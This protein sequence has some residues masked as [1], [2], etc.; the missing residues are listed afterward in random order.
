MAKQN[1]WLLYTLAVRNTRNVVGDKKTLAF[2]T[3]LGF[4]IYCCEV[5]KVRIIMLMLA[6][7]YSNTV[8]CFNFPTVSPDY[9]HP[10]P[11]RFPLF[12]GWQTRYYMGYNLPSYEYLYHSGNQYMLKMRY[13]DHVFNDQFVESVTVKIILP[14]GAR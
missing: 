10:L 4:A 11:A 13:L 9:P 5:V 2:C 6:K 7:H 8:N 14:E 3:N 1:A 12:G